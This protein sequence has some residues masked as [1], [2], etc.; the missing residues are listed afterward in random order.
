MNNY[1]QVLRMAKTVVQKFEAETN[2]GQ[3]YMTTVNIQ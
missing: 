2:T 1:E 3:N